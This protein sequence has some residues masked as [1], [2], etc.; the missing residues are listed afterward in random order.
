MLKPLLVDGDPEAAA[1]GIGD[2]YRD[3][4]HEDLGLDVDQWDLL[5]RLCSSA[6]SRCRTVWRALDINGAIPRSG[7]AIMS[8]G[9]IDGLY[10]VS[11]SFSVF[12]SS[13]RSAR[14][15]PPRT[16]RKDRICS[17]RGRKPSSVISSNSMLCKIL[18]S[19]DSVR[20]DFLA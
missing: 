10:F 9:N 7:T 20:G 1:G 3:R 4:R 15:R 18:R 5:D 19:R 16:G 17:R 14:G 8:S 13:A 6:A 11:P 2:G 12:D